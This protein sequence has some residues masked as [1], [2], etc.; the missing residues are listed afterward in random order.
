MLQQKHLR[1]LTLL[2]LIIAFSSQAQILPEREQIDGWL[3]ELGGENSFD[4]SKT[5]DW[6][7]LPG[8]FY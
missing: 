1:R 8:P 7:V 6:G 4:E 3:S 5:I 2:S